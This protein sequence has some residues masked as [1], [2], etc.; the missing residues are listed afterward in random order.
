MEHSAAKDMDFF[1]QELV[2]TKTSKKR[3]RE[4]LQWTQAQLHVDAN[5]AL[6]LLDVK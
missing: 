6:S 2:E 4:F 1:S 3:V 5:V